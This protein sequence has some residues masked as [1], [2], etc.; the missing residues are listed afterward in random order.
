MSQYGEHIPSRTYFGHSKSD[1]KDHPK[2]REYKTL[3]CEDQINLI[4]TEVIEKGINIRIAESCT[5]GG[6][7]NSIT[8]IGG[9]SKIMDFNIVAYSSKVKEKILGLEPHFTSKKMIVSIG[10]SRH[11]NWGLQE[12]CK[13][14]P[15]KADIYVSITGTIDTK[16]A[17]LCKD[18]AIFTLC[19][20]EKKLMLTYDVDISIGR[21]REEK[22]LFL[23]K[24]ILLEI[25]DYVEEIKR[26]PDKNVDRSRLIDSK[27]SGMFVPA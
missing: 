25:L 11:M 19:D 18:R 8:N 15:K 2:W 20:G 7:S 23:I 1:V 14:L 5:G 4:A 12:L 3:F 27:I 16:P 22:K 9:S 21:S 10:T 6:I 26:I 13:D 24:R 17:K